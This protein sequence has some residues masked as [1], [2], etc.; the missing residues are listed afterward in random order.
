MICFLP[1]Q[2]AIE[3]GVWT[4][5]RI[6]LL[7]IMFYCIFIELNKSRE[8]KKEESKKEESYIFIWRQESNCKF[9]GFIL[10]ADD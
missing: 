2:I 4:S 10:M 6:F 3:S 7:E 1:S 5:N 9:I 8:K